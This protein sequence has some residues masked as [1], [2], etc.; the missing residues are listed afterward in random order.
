MISSPRWTLCICPFH[1]AIVQPH[2][3][4][5]KNNSTLVSSCSYLNKENIFL[6]SQL[7]E[8][9]KKKQQDG[10]GQLTTLL[11]ILADHI[12][13]RV[14]DYVHITDRHQNGINRN[15]KKQVS[16]FW[17]NSTQ[18]TKWPHTYIKAV[19]K[20]LGSA[21]HF[22]LQVIPN[23]R[24]DENAAF[25]IHFYGHPVTQLWYWTPDT[26][27]TYTKELSSACASFSETQLLSHC[28]LQQWFI[29]ML[30]GDLANY[31]T[32]CQL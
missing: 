6:G 21:C 3:R 32:K 15:I 14:R 13:C 30:L 2:H 31:T 22:M 12:F 27:T 23:N 8:K 29:I 7:Q 19:A 9:C 24:Y 4:K 17:N 18:L 16:L 25:V 28:I 10:L 1:I 11:S 20:D 26:S 5:K